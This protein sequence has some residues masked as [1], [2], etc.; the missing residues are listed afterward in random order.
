MQLASADPFCIGVKI[1]LSRATTNG[2]KNEREG[3]R[4][5]LQIAAGAPIAAAQWRERA[6]PPQI[7]L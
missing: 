2:G 4:R 6:L 7:H 3:F 1:R 5:A